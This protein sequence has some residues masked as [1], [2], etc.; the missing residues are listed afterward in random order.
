[1]GDIIEWNEKRKVYR[2][3]SYHVIAL[4]GGFLLD[5]LLGNPP[6]LLQPKNILRKRVQYIFEKSEYSASSRFMSGLAIFGMIAFGLFTILATLTA[7]YWWK[8]IV[9][10]ILEMWMTYQLLGMRALKVRS[11]EVLDELLHGNPEKAERLAKQL[12]NPYGD[13]VE[14]TAISYVAGNMLEEIL[15]P[16]FLMAVGGPALGWLG[17]ALF[18]LTQ[19]CRKAQRGDSKVLEIA[20]G[21]L[22]FL[23]AKAGEILV[24]IACGV[25]GNTYD[26]DNVISYYQEK[27]GVPD[28]KRL[29]QLSI[30]ALGNRKREP[31]DILRINHL[32]YM[33]GKLWLLFWLV[34]LV[35]IQFVSG[36]F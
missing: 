4:I 22:S 19:Y 8:P 13:N 15:L 33:V 16:V 11:C 14:E 2:K 7:A 27:D 6:F 17:I 34:V 10:C 36:L 18:C 28:E 1:M 26:W 24:L 29:E 30:K 32:S 35:G 21:F 9:G 23:P 5:L 20:T 25:L 12:A 3:M 31:L